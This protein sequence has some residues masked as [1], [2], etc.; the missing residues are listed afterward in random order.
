MAINSVNTS[1]NCSGNVD[2]MNG[3]T[4]G[5]EIEYTGASR[6]AVAAAIQSVVGGTVHRERSYDRRVVTAADGRKW[7]VVH[8]GSVHGSGW[9][10]GGEIVSPVLRGMTG[11]GDDMEVLQNVIRAARRAGARRDSSAGIH[12]HVDGSAF[13]A[14]AIQRLFKLYYTNEE[15]IKV[16]VAPNADRRASRFNA[17]RGWARP[18]NEGRSG[19]AAARIMK[20]RRPTHDSIC[21]EYYRG[22]Y[23]SRRP[24][25]CEADAARGSDQYSPAGLG[26]YVDARYR[27]INLHSFYFE[28]RRSVEFR[29]FDTTLHAGR[30]KSYVQFCLALS[31]RA[32][33]TKRARVG[34]KTEATREAARL[35]T[36]KSG[37][38]GDLFATAREFMVRR[39]F[40]ERDNGTPASNC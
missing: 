8:D 28:N 14:P 2:T 18:M 32:I 10:E 17:S 5:V 26:H 1:W 12:V 16:M 31:A 15:L 11:E 25:N 9:N 36:V 13:T 3:L 7:N 24:I 23:D 27:A 40:N 4:Y 19:D 38:S 29:I 34:R 20:L 6:D 22:E 21:R 39:S 33:N 35:F 37:M 30:V